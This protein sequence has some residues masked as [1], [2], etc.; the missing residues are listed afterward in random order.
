VAVIVP[1]IDAA[2]RCKRVERGAHR[3]IALGMHMDLKARSIQLGDQSVQTRRL[4][5]Q[6][7]A[8]KFP[9]VVG[10]GL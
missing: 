5:K 2:C 10:V 1:A 9:R 4:N 7:P 6:L 3:T 8:A